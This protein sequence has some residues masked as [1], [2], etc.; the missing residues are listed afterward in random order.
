MSCLAG[1]DFSIGD[2]E[3]SRGRGL[4]KMKC[5]KLGHCLPINGCLA[6]GRLLQEMIDQIV[7]YSCF[8]LLTAKVVADV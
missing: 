3:S 5:L 1:Q 7:I 2:L 4:L 6:N 8:L